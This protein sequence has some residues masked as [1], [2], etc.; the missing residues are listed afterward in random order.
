MGATLI[1]NIMREYRQVFTQA[2]AVVIIVFGIL[3]IFGKGFSGLNVYLKGSHRTPVGSY[4]FGS[5]FAIGWSACIGPILAS[6]LLLSAASGTMLKG[7]SLLFIYALGLAVPLII[8]SL[9]FD[10]VRSNKFWKVL[11]GRE[12]SLHVFKQHISVHSTYLISGLILIVLGVLIFNDYMFKL[13]QLTFQTDYVQN[14]IVR[15]EEFLKGLF[16]Q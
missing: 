14:I 7:T 16:T 2:A 12:L 8:V 4:L 3:E 10:R 15:G 11:Q 1:G 13:N 6:F 5:V 9:F